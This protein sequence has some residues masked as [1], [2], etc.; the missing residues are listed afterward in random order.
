MRWQFLLT[1]YLMSINL[2][3][4]VLYGQDKRRARRGQWRISE[5]LLLECALAGGGV[6]A[7]LGM[8]LFR[9]KI[10]HRKF[11]LLVPFSILLWIGIVILFLI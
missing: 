3:T 4:F 8:L 11:R 1:G 7:G 9:H 6:G 2:F 10:R 5:R